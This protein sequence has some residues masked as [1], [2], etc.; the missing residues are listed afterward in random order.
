MTF[1]VHA[2]V[3]TPPRDSHDKTENGY[4]D[5]EAG[6]NGTLLPSDVPYKVKSELWRQLFTEF[7]GTFIMVTFGLGGIAQV[8]LSGGDAGNFTN[9]AISWG[10]AVMMGLH[11]AGGVS[12]AHLN[13]MI[14]TS[15]I[16]LKMFPLRKVPAFI[17]TQT[18]ASF[19]AAAV[20]YV[21]YRP[22][23]NEID[24]DRETSHTIFA[25]Y[26]H[27]GVGNFTALLTEIFAGAVFVFCILAL[28]DKHN[29]PIGAH[30]APTGVAAIVVG[31]AMAF[32]VNTGLALNPARDFG[33]RLFMLLAGWGSKVFTL[34]SY[35]FWIPIVGPIV[36]GAIGAW[37][38]VGLILHHHPENPHQPHKEHRF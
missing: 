8:T 9:I 14:T 26:P 22:L 6:A 7:L 13:P 25:T 34:N 33:P 5:I 19:V 31:L 18:L 20:I 15:L 23:L 17:A 32:G 11:T 35:Y 16:V 29:R 10:V 2:P 3:T 12:G 37:V 27:A 38:Y 36:G 4:Y 30:A 24:P 21:L 28:L 1:E